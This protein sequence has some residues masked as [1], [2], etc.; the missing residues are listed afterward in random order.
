MKKVKSIT[1]H[2]SNFFEDGL[3]MEF[4]D[5]LNCLMGGRGTGKS[6]ILHFIQACL[7]PKVDEDQ[8][9]SNLLRSNLHNGGIELVLQG[10]DGKEYHVMKTLGVEPLISVDG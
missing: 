2:K 6:T 3:S 1:V 4:S 5:L 10:D 7:D 9:I 8:H